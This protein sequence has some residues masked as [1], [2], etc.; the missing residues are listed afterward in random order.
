MC[1]GRTF[2]V[3]ALG[4]MV[5][6][7][8]SAGGCGN[9]GRRGDDVARISREFVESYFKTHPVYATWAGDHRY[10]DRIDDM[11]DIAVAAELKTLKDYRARLEGL[12]RAGLSLKDKIDAEMLGYEIERGISDIEDLR[13]YR[14]DPLVYTQLLGSSINYL[15]ARDYAPLDERLD[16]AAARLEQFPRAVDQAMRNLTEPTKARTDM[17]IAQNRGTIKLLEVD[18]RHVAA[19]APS[20]TEKVA[21]AI[22]PAGQALRVFQDYLERDLARRSTGDFRLGDPLFRRRLALVLQ[23][24]M[25]S[26]DIVAE[27]YAE[28]DRIHER[29]YDLAAPLYADMVSRQPFAAP[30]HE[31]RKEIIRRV[32]GDISRDHPKASALLDSCRAAFTEAARFVRE[33]DIIAIP[34]EPLEI[35]WT[36][37]YMRGVSTTGLDSPGPL[38][39][40]MKSFLV[41]SP[42][43]DYLSPRQVEAFLREYNTEMLR[44]ITIHEAMPGHFVQLAYAN[45]NPSIVRSIFPNEAFVEGWAVYCMEMMPAEGFRAGDARFRLQAEKLYVRSVINAILDAGVHR[46]GMTEYE[47][48]KLMIDEGFQEESEAVMK[49]DRAVLF[50]GY[51]STYFVGCREIRSLGEEAEV[52]WGGS[53]RPSEFHERLLRQGAIPFP[54]VREMLFGQ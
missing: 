23:S 7:A 31:G 32:L 24:D 52:R 6:C 14:L 51:L 18:L 40:G 41:V 50:P 3:A 5:C 27:A 16:M 25:T 15:I 33:K 49:W 30:P 28:I 13:M 10:D 35:I 45:R 47:A 53:F 17:A 8:L 19:G 9:A 34:P 37:E 4:V 36:P 42:P 29:M 48:M 21:R 44:V 11:S 38:E 46:G 26:E 1:R 39:K 12:D 54:Y 2:G 43:P 22:G 20:R